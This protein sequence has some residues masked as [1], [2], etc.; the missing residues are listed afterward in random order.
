MIFQVDYHFHPNLPS[1]PQEALAKCQSWWQAL[2]KAG[3][4]AIIVT[5]H[6]Y[7]NPQ[8][9][10]RLMLQ[11]K[12]DDCYV[13][14]GME[15]LTKENID[16]VIFSDN[17][18]FFQADQLLPYEL[19]LEKAI[20]FVQQNNLAAY[21]PHPFT[22][23]NTSPIKK[24]GKT[25]L[26]K[27][28]DKLGAV[29][30][31]NCCFNNL[32]DIL[33]VWPYRDLFSRHITQMKKVRNLPTEFYPEKIKFLAVSSD[34]HHLEEVGPHV[35]IECQPDQLYQAIINNQQ[36]K[37]VIPKKSFNLKLLFKSIR[38]ALSEYFAKK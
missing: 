28:I 8:T 6:V 31:T 30:I 29:E 10:Y 11:T 18:Q 21:I 13:F 5:E 7:K 34:S 1:N 12:P 26:K 2:K 35:E 4:N 33:N 14:P 23:G 20:D 25:K 36:P 9:A 32:L 27:L 15:Y 17:D 16:L 24:L 37:I 22:V 38:T 19:S 3:I